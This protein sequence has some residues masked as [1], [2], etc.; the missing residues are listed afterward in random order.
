MDQAT[1]TAK[2]VYNALA[3]KLW[4]PNICGW[5]RTL[6]DWD[7]APKIKLFTWLL[8]E[9][10]ILTWDNLQRRGWSG[11]SICYLCLQKPKTTFTPYGSVQFHSAGMDYDL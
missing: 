2:N 4:I 1:L 9:D 3:S 7:L 6:W 8:L 11:P 5:Q 10:K